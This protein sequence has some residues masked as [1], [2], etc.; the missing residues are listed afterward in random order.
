MAE[1]ALTEY[2]TVVYAA[3]TAAQL[4]TKT[5]TEGLTPDLL[6]DIIVF[7]RDAHEKLVVKE[8]LGSVLVQVAKFILAPDAAAADEIVAQWGPERISSRTAIFLHVAVM[9][10]T[11]GLTQKQLTELVSDVVM[12]LF[13]DSGMD[14]EDF[15]DIAVEPQDRKYFEFVR[16]H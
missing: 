13:S 6:R 3:K 15:L 5:E 14:P 2:R 16:I 9:C 1:F 8:S 12:V 7:L 10:M 4:S 11:R